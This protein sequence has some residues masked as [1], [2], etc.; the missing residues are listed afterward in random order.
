VN[1]IEVV[2]ITANKEKR[3]K[4]KKDKAN[5]EKYK[6]VSLESLFDYIKQLEMRVEKLEKGK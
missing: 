4:A 1:K 6:D 5:K 2:N 3:N